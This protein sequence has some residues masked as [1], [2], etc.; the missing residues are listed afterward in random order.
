MHRVV[1]TGI[2]ITSSIGT[3]VDEV[4]SSL[5]HGKSGIVAAPEYTE[6]G[7][8]SQ[9]HGTVK[10]NLE[11]HVDRKQ[12]RF[13]GEGAAYA[14]LAM[15]QAVEDAGL[16]PDEVSHP[17]SGL[18]AGS[19][20]PSTY[21]LM[22]AAD[23]TREKGPKRIGPYMVPRCMSSSVSACIATFF[24]IKGLNYSISSACS[25]SAHCISTGAD[26]IRFGQQDIVFAGGGEELHWTLSVLFDAMGA[27]SSAYNDNPTAASR[28][29]DSNRDGFI[30]A[31]GGGMVVLESLD[32]ALARGAKIYGE[33]VGT[34]AN[35]DGF[36]MVA[37]SGEGAV[38]CM[39][40]ALTGFDGNG[41]EQ[42][43]DYINTHGTST[44]VGDIKEL[45]AIRSVFEPKGKLPYI[46][47][48]KSLTGHSLGATGVQEAIYTLI[49]MKDGFIAGNAN[50]DDPDPGIGDIP[51]V[52][53]SM[54]H[55]IDLAISNSFGFGGTNSTLAIKRY[56]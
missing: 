3:S 46:S 21:N 54:D 19:G 39:E 9:V 51:V 36:D 26:A 10:I 24:Q 37:P 55:Q 42:S 38:R 30:I 34:G 17:R 18:I 22:Q 33:I 14:V 48:T 23:I 27:M 45:D 53:K 16:T 25:T 31:G 49:M 4:S 56:N 15:Q 12:M 47:S 50:L 5:R 1:I 2:G 32:H 44:P 6:L 40:L 52:S 29:Y 13:M 8:R 20:G 43:V 11:D 35:S 41:L 28:P 7:F